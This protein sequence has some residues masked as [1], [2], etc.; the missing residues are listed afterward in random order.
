MSAAA[1]GQDANF[2]SRL[3][4]MENAIFKLGSTLEKLISTKS[5][6]GKSRRENDREYL[7]DFSLN[8][9][10]S[11]IDQSSDEDSNCAS[12]PQKKLSR[13]VVNADIC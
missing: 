5:P 7:T 13:N 6:S 8:A 2:E 9:S 10:Q 1:T 4:A 3:N 11:E 12:F